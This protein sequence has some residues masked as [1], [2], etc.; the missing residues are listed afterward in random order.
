[1]DPGAQVLAPRI[2]RSLHMTIPTL[3][4]VPSKSPRVGLGFT[5]PLLHSGLRPHLGILAQR[6]HLA[7]EG[8]GLLPQRLRVADVAHD[9]LLEWEL[10]TLLH[11]LFYICRHLHDLSAHCTGPST[12]LEVITRDCS[13]AVG[14]SAAYCLQQEWDG[15]PFRLH[16]WEMRY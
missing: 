5:V 14:S 6:Q 2:N 1:M 11:L 16:Y 8:D 4:C 12:A 13:W 10:L 15:I 7:E 3:P 9:H